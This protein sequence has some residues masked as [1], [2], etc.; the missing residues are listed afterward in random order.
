M[1]FRTRFEKG[2]DERAKDYT[3]SLPFD[4]RLYK[5][6]IAGSIAHARMLAKQGII[7][8]KDAELIIMGLTSIR[9]EIEQGK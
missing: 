1:S 3:V 9:E 2:M 4:R 6:D 8:D 5:Q 7:S